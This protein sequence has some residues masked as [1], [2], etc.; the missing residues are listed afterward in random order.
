VRT[1]EPPVA[2]IP[3]P[4]RVAPSSDGLRLIASGMGYLLVVCLVVIGTSL[5]SI[6]QGAA[7]VPSRLFD[8]RD[9]IA[10]FGW[11][12]MMITG[13]TVIIVP[14]HLGVRLR[15]LYLPNLHF[16]LA[17]VGLVG[18]FCTS[19]LS[20]S[21]LAPDVFLALVAASFLVF[22]L[23]VLATVSPFVFLSR[24]SAKGESSPKSG[25]RTVG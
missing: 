11:V 15:P 18:F 10:L 23:G 8:D 4:R 20:T 13:V 25:R 9:L 14:N 6:L 16:G 24:A 1:N 5:M 2:W 12:G 22:G 17:N 7:S 19:L 3:P 21:S